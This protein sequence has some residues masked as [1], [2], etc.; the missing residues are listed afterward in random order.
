M[1]IDD[2]ASEM[3]ESCTRKDQ[4]KLKD[5]CL[6]RDGYR[7]VLTGIWDKTAKDRCP[8]A[9][10]GRCI[11]AT[12]LAHIIPFSMGKWDGEDEVSFYSQHY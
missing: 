10:R 8:P 9:D 5:L 7:C 1:T 4:P 6:K 3:D 12:E 2:I 11:G